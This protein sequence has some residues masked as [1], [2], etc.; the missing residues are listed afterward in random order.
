MDEKLLSTLEFDKIRLLLA[1]RA[2]FSGGKNIAEALWPSRSLKEAE[3]W[4]AETEEAVRI[5]AAG[6]PPP[7]GGMRDVREIVRRAERGALLQ[8]TEILEVADAARA[9]DRLRA[10]LET[11]APTVGAE[12][13]ADLAGILGR[14]PRLERE[15][16]RCLSQDGE[17]VD[18][19]SPKL[20]EVRS[21]L[22]TVRQRVREYLEGLVR[23]AKGQRFLQ[24][25]IV[26]VRNGRY[27]V[28]VKQEYRSEIPGIVHDHSASGA[29]L[30]VEPAAVVEMNNEIRRFEAEE[31]RE[32]ERV[33]QNLS[34][35]IAS[36]ADRLVESVEIAAELDFIF[37]KGRLALD[38]NAVK[39][40]LNAEGRIDI[41]KARHPLIRGEVVPVDIRLGGEFTAL[42]ITGPNTGGK[43]VALKTIGLFVLM[44]QAGLHLP[45]D[46]GSEVGLF[47]RL[48][49]DI[50]DEQSIEQSL[51]TF[52]AHMAN[53]VRILDAVDDRSLVLLDELGAGTDPSEGAALAVAVLERLVEKGSRVVV[54]THFGALKR[55]A[56]THPQVENASV[57]FDVETL[58]PTY[59][60]SIGHAGKSHAFAIAER[61]G[62]APGVI[63]RARSHLSEQEREVE[64]LLG[65]V[66]E[67]RLLAEKDREEAQRLRREYLELRDRYF[68]AFERLKAAREK[69]LEEARREAEAL[70]TKARREAEA[71]LGRLRK[72]GREDLEAQAHEVRTRLISLAEEVQSLEPEPPPVRSGP[73]G[74]VA[75]F[76]PAPGMPVR[77][78]SLGKEGEVVQLFA[79]GKV[80]VQV[81]ALKVTVERSDLEPLAR[82]R[83]QAAAPAYGAI[84]FRKAGQIQTEVDLRGML[85]SEAIERLDK[86]L[87]DAILAGLERVRVIHGKGTGALREGVWAYL[88]GHP[89]VRGFQLGEASEGGA[90]VTL[91][92]L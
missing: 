4:Q 72:S 65:N 66:E 69:V 78:R 79:D 16:Q 76:E 22:R 46:E 6:S 3:R 68:D 37:A 35:L 10:F 73:A 57:Q 13:L 5:L 77:V 70:L 25:A 53:I 86:Y 45:A 62:L 41:R 1:E 87:D 51:S 44:A 2:A 84:A 58:R 39:P 26:T 56:Y 29:T 15:I 42:V 8:P 83:P 32:V 63:E 40:Q 23:S 74:Q 88:K 27:V 17:V 34:A 21:R 48:F 52:S 30:F 61:L 64:D 71:L 18:H 54:T 14:F 80:G 20:A 47:T 36:E 43:T 89:R 50:G 19:A 33:L 12:T 67:S 92:E 85:V 49:A 31:A 7:F 9:S 55:L 59:K 82:P 28:P 81:G 24:E 90:G 60:L 75:G 91:V 38:W 11:C